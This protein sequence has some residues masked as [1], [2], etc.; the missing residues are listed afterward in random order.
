MNAPL[1][2]ALLPAVAAGACAA[3][4]YWRLRHSAA[5]A[6]ASRGCEPAGLPPRP[7]ATAPRTPR[8]S[9]W[10]AKPGHRTPRP[11]AVAKAARHPTWTGRAR[12]APAPQTPG[13]LVIDEAGRFWAAPAHAGHDADALAPIWASHWSAGPPTPHLAR[14][15]SA[16]DRLRAAPAAWRGWGAWEQAHDAR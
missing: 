10:P 16:P 2:I 6:A 12:V 9:T 8:P 5:E 14:P 1:L 7:A 11:P 4:Y 3:A 13:A 15:A